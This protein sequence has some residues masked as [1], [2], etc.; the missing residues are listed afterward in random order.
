MIAACP[1]CGAP[2]REFDTIQ[3]RSGEIVGTIWTCA[4]TEGFWCDARGDLE[5]WCY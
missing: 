1:L 3:D 4:C 5:E 2:L